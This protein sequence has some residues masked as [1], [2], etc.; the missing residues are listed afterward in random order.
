ME[1][2]ISEKK[3][4]EI[5][6]MTN[7]ELILL[8]LYGIMIFGGSNMWRS[9]SRICVYIVCFIYISTTIFAC[10]RSN[11]MYNDIQLALFKE[12]GKYGYLD[13]DGNV[14]IKPKYNYAE[15]F[16][17]GLAAVADTPSKWGYIDTTGRI[18]IKSKYFE[19]GEFVDG[20]ALVSIA[21]STDEDR[22]IYIDRDGK[23]LFNKEFQL[24]Y[25]FSE[26]FALVLTQGYGAPLPPS[27]N[28]PQKWSYINATGA[29]AT[30]MEFDAAFSFNNGYAAVQVDGKWGLIDKDF[31]LVIDYIYDMPVYYP[32]SEK[33]H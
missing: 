24:A 17:E 15:E 14:V 32:Y 27:L 5:G 10:G 16:S 4:C 26:G 6:T 7:G 31:V 33:G 8:S 20:I 25:S 28:I 11:V 19:A 3:I 9:V 22:W 21:K 18:A 13:S 30:E 2:N 1:S 12:D 23:Q 29:L